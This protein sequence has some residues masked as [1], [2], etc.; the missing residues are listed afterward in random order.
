MQPARVLSALMARLGLEFMPRQLDW[1]GRE[2]HDA[3]GNRMRR[4]PA[5]IRLDIHWKHGLNVWQ[6]VGI[7]VFSR[8]LSRE[9]DV[10]KLASLILPDRGQRGGSPG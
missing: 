4:R 8:M 2:R 5:D 9:D 10:R 3:G 1:S 7:S 6:K